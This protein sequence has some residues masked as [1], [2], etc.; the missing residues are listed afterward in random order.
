LKG[1]RDVGVQRGLSFQSINCSKMSVYCR[2]VRIYV[3]IVVAPPLNRVLNRVP[4]SRLNRPK[5]SLRHIGF[6]VW[7]NVA[8]LHRILVAGDIQCSFV[9]CIYL[10]VCINVF[11][12]GP[13]WEYKPNSAH[14]FLLVN[15]IHIF[16]NP[17]TASSI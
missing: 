1:A 10:R 7:D 3:I 15:Y 13:E 12:R 6:A 9:Y 8:L 4:E 5:S 16:K 14:G 2:F 11:R 17:R